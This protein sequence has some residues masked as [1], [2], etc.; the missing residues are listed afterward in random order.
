MS[1]RLLATLLVLGPFC[2]APARSQSPVDEAHLIRRHLRVPATT[3]IVLAHTPKLP[4]EPVR[5]Y[6]AVGLDS[7]VRDYFRRSVDGW[8]RDQRG[9]TRYVS[10][11]RRLEEANIVILRF[12]LPDRATSEVRSGVQTVQVTDGSG[13]THQEAVPT[14]DTVTVVPSYG[15]VLRRT[16]DGFEVLA[17]YAAM[18]PFGRDAHYVALW[19][20]LERLIGPSDRKRRFLWW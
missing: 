20:R 17:R 15:Y 13:Q 7:S 2:A 12:E 19:E 9:P 8:N 11:A 3:E 16:P 14:T 18:E 4:T 1:I 5:V 6:L 10:L